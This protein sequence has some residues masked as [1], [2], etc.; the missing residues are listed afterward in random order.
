MK[1]DNI[2]Y[3]LQNRIIQTSQTGGQPYCDTSP[4]SIPF[5]KWCLYYKSDLALIRV[6]NYAP[7]VT[8]QIVASLTDDSRGIIY[9]NYMLIEQASEG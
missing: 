1:T 4:F 2:C 9:N 3:Y 8:L 6:V 7:R 5:Q